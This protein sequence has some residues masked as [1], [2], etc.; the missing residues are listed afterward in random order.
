M[1]AAAGLRV[2]R[3]ELEWIVGGKGGCLACIVDYQVVRFA[4]GLSGHLLWL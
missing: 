3:V 4:V 2:L 1:A